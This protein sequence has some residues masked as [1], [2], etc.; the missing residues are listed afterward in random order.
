LEKGSVVDVPSARV[1]TVRLDGGKVRC[2]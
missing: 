2:D 1:A